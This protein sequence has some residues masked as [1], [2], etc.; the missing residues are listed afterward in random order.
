M[1]ET[2]YWN[3]PPFEILKCILEHVGINEYAKNGAVYQCQLV[4]KGWY[5]AAQEKLYRRVWLSTNATMFLES[6]TRSRTKI[7]MHVKEVTY[8]R[9]FST[10]YN[11]NQILQSIINFSPNIQELYAYDSAEK[12][13]VYSFLVS[14]NA[15]LKKTQRNSNLKKPHARENVI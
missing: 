10:F 8:S 12:T 6:I 3:D 13:L 11:S 9:G 7:G 4:C 14:G 5:I 1:A 15:H 2:I